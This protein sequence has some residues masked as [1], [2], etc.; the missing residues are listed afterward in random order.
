MTREI[1]IPPGWNVSLL[2]VHVN[3]FIRLPELLPKIHFWTC[4]RFSGWIWAKLARVYS[5]RHLQHDSNPIFPLEL[6]FTTFLLG[7]AQKSKFVGQV[8]GQ[9]S[10]LPLKAFLFLMFFSPFLFLLLIVTDLLQNGLLRQF[11]GFWKQKIHSVWPFPWKQPVWQN[12]SQERTN[13]NA[14]IY[15]KTTL[16]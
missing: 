9:E 1:A 11:A 15:L 6:C 12:P 2:Y 14:C 3:P 7:H 8:F 13:E 4:W 16:P 5:K 10:E